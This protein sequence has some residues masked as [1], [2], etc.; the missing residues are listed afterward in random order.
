M[1]TVAGQDLVAGAI[2]LNPPGSGKASSS[3]GRDMFRRLDVGTGA[4]FV[5]QLVIPGCEYVPFALG[6]LLALRGIG[7]GAGVIVHCHCLGSSLKVI[8]TR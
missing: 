1:Q 8:S 6:L 7:V 4:H 3:Q 5:I 2:N